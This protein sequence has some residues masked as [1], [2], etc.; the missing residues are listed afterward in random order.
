MRKIII[1]AVIAIL[2]AIAMAKGNEDGIGLG[3][4]L[5][6]FFYILESWF[7]VFW[8]WLYATGLILRRILSFLGTCFIL[9]VPTAIGE[10]LLP[11]NWV[12][13]V[14]TVIGTIILFVS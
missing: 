8:Q 1:K 6:L 12:R 4:V 9:M 14:L 2:L 13:I 5:T 11:D 10:A 7:G 3:I